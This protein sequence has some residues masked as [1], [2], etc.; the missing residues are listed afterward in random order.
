MKESAVSN[1]RN[2]STSTPA[3]RSSVVSA[4]SPRKRSLKPIE[5]SPFDP[6]YDDDD[7]L[8]ETFLFSE[9]NGNEEGFYSEDE[10][11]NDSDEDIDE[12]LKRDFVDEMTG[13]Q[14]NKNSIN[15]K[16]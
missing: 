14:Q 11:E 9:S 1:F 2:A 5:G 6:S 8:E 16:K 4:V 7:N 12:E 15:L 3:K 13:D 10:G